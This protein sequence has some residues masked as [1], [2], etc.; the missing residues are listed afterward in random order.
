MNIP[1]NLKYASTH[2]WVRPEGEIAVIGITD[3]AQNHLGDI[4]F[5]ELPA[6]GAKLEAGQI[7]GSVESVK[8][9]S[10]LYSPV[11]G[12]VMEINTAL[13]SA[14]ELVNRE[15][16]AGGWMVRVKYAALPEDLLSSEDYARITSE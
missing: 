6:A 7:M 4:T 13:D 1:A 16:Y 11:S 8:A 15:P 9:A 2:E 5:V 12:L 14:P 3:F 10:D